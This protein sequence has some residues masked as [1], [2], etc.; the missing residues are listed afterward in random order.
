MRPEIPSCLLALHFTL[1]QAIGSFLSLQVACPSKHSGR[2]R[3][4][5]VTAPGDVGFFQQL[6]PRCRAF[7]G[8]AAQIFINCD[9]ERCKSFDVNRHDFAYSDIPQNDDGGGG[10]G[11]GGGAASRKLAVQSEWQ[12][13]FRGRAPQPTVAGPGCPS[14][15]SCSS[16]PSE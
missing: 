12:P 10:G 3:A 13:R 15:G 16:R 1:N 8:I 9:F 6:R 2:T 11:D 4:L 5:I 7:A 14:C